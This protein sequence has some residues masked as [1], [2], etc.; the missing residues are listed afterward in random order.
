[1]IP[2]IVGKIAY[3][4]GISTHLLFAICTVESGF[5]N[6]NN[7]TDNQGPAFGVCQLHG[8]TAKEMLPYVDALAL[9]QPKVNLLVA[10]LYL[11]KQ[12]NRYGNLTDVIASYNAG[13]V[14]IVN[15]EYTNKEYVDKVVSVMDNI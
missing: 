12:Q 7:Y 2:L 15:N 8:D 3:S 11:K 10:A 13:S 1:M 5:K 6:V 4:V 9:M 14:F